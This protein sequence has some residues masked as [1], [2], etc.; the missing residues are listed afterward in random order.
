MYKY[1]EDII[2]GIIYEEV[3]SC[4]MS[5]GLSLGRY[6]RIKEWYW[7][8]VISVCEIIVV[9]VVEILI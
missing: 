5:L 9:V 7:L 2:V 3:I 8:I 6:G 1:G 4:L